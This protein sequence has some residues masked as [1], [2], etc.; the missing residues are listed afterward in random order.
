MTVIDAA[1]NAEIRFHIYVSALVLKWNSSYVFVFVFVVK[2]VVCNSCI[3]WKCYFL[4]VVAIALAFDSRYNSHS[5]CNFQLFRSCCT[6][7]YIVIQFRKSP[8]SVYHLRT[9][10]RVIEAL[11]VL[12]RKKNLSNNNKNEMESRY[13]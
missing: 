3:N 12:S 10:M 7:N 2:H 5:K 1:N 6:N 4:Y 11:S 13:L 8:F 9:V